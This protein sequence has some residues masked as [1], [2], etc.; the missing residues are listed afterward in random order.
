A[1]PRASCPVRPYARRSSGP[2][3]A[4]LL[5]CP[6]SRRYCGRTCARERGVERPSHVAH[7]DHA[8]ETV[9]GDDEGGRRIHA[10]ARLVATG[11]RAHERCAYAAVVIGANERYHLVRR[12][13]LP[14]CGDIHAE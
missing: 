4:P 9:I 7:R 5:L 2:T 8:R 3:A 6:G 12:H 14:I 13:T 11:L 1:A 10:D